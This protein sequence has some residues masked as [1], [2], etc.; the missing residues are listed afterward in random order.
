MSAPGGS[1]KVVLAYSLVELIQITQTL[2]RLDGVL[3][4]ALET[5]PVVEG[6]TSGSE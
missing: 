6:M 4:P 3:H 2:P 5:F 1:N